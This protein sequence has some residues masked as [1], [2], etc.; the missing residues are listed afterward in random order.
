M[1]SFSKSREQ[2]I[3]ELGEMYEFNLGLTPPHREDFIEKLAGYDKE[4]AQ[5]L[6]EF[7]DD[8]L[9]DA[10]R[11]SNSHDRVT[12][13]LDRLDADRISGRVFIFHE[14][15]DEIYRLIFDN[16]RLGVYDSH[17]D[18]WGFLPE[19]VKELELRER[20]KNITNSVERRETWREIKRL[21]QRT[22]VLEEALSEIVPDENQQELQ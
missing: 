6:S 1:A 16:D 12:E 20:V 14:G 15:R 8:D 7:S 19:R 18:E 2:E 13:E 5:S 3:P 21:N 9:I 4:E 11:W 22:N 17:R 10:M